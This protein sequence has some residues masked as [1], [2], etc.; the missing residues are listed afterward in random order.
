V[1]SDWQ[2]S[3]AHA[4]M[5]D[6]VTVVAYLFAAVLSA[7]A[8]RCAWLRREPRDRVFWNITA[9]LLIFL[10]I[11]EL[12]DL[13]TLLTMVGR[14]HAIANGWYPEHR[15]IQYLFIIGLSATAMLV[16]IAMILLTMRT[17]PA[18]RIALLGLVF[19]GLFVLL[20]AASFHHLDDLLGSGASEFNWGSVQEMVGIFI[21]A[22]AAG[23]YTRNRRT[24]I[25]QSRNAK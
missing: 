2:S 9:S 7:R 21:V 19:I 6:W 8:A 20:R 13:Q 3:I 24:A 11:N 15:R 1:I 18:V 23:F 5:A 17:H 4:D 10:G 14:A 25:Q 16:G 22:G 12:L